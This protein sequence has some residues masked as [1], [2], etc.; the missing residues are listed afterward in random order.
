MMNDM[1]PTLEETITPDTQAQFEHEEHERGQQLL[2]EQESWADLV[3]VHG[4]LM[5]D[6]E[7]KQYKSEYEG[8][9]DMQ[10]KD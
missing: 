9:L 4:S 5:T 3:A 1:M 6:A 10:W 8:Y 2:L 7:W